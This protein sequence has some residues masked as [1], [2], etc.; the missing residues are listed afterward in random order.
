[1]RKR[2]R[3]DHPV[4]KPAARGS[5]AQAMAIAAS[6][7]KRKAADKAA[8]VKAKKARKASSKAFWETA[9]IEGEVT[10]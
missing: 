7:T 9:N 3:E 8:D 2:L 1:M 5:K 10:F 6:P 4:A